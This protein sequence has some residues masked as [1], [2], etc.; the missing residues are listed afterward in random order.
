MS[1]PFT[2]VSHWLDQ[3]APRL[4]H[5][6]WLGLVGMIAAGVSTGFTA[7]SV[8]VL[9]AAGLPGALGLVLGGALKARNDGV[10]FLM[11]LAWTGPGIAAALTLG[12]VL[13]PA[14]LAFLAGPAALAASGLRADIRLSA[15]INTLAFVLAGL[16][17]L[18]GPL[19]AGV[20]ALTSSSEV[21]AISGVG[22]AVF[23]AVT[24][25]VSRA[26]LQS[27]LDA[28]RTE[29]ELQAPAAQGFF[30]APSAIMML[31]K[32]GRIQAVSRRLRQYTPGAPRDLAG[33][34]VDGLAFQDE[35]RDEICAG[36]ASA[37]DT[38]EAG[39]R[40]TFTVRAARGARSELIAH[41]VPLETGFILCLD[42]P[43][44]Q[45]TAP[46][47]AVD[48]TQLE[49]ERDAAVAANRS[50]SEFLAA[51]SHELRTPLN[52]IIGF[53]DIIKQRLFGPLPARYAEYGDLIHESGEHLLELIGDV[54]DMSK[55]EADRYELTPEDFDA[56]DVIGICA[57]MIKPR[58]SD[59]GLALYCE[60]GDVELP[61]LADRKAMR[62]ILLNLLSNAVK[63]TPENG[64]VVVM[65]RQEGAELVLAVGDSGVGIAADE[66]ADLGKPYH[67]TSSGK[68]TDE[69]G[70]GLGLSLV[71]ALAELQNGTVRV[72]SAPG[73]GTTVTVRLPIMAE[74]DA[75]VTDFV[76]LEVHQRIQAAQNAGDI[77]VKETNGAA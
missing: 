39:N 60:T 30:Q 4:V 70:T 71:Q 52:A 51:V 5:A 24:G 37:R 35:D 42:E 58:A 12:T 10:R 19:G 33:L 55:I 41:A 9:C 7:S 44:V 23:F 21:I 43:K 34:P 22:L 25:F 26:S 2:L 11:A 59:R 40:F 57:K 54:L 67:Q 14:A 64:A 27:Q 3:Q 6:A 15:A 1:A 38:G 62:Q 74:Q 56:R 8:M 65:A 18:A 46:L 20:G 29:L 76:P 66:L 77:I 63:F 17:S 61:V 31:D 32:A 16:A 50:K 69:R 49:A 75:E 45:E 73:E 13:S 68:R 28:V 48:T 53:S 72:Q 47:A 36:L